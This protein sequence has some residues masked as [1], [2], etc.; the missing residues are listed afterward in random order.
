MNRS[1]IQLFSTATIL[2]AGGVVSCSADNGGGGGGSGYGGA[3]FGGGGGGAGGT[4]PGGNGGM[5][6]GGMGGGGMGGGGMG[7]GGM[8]GGGMGGSG[9][10]CKTPTKLHPPKSDAGTSNIYCP[11]SG[12]D[13][14]MNDYCASG[15][16]HCCEP[17][18]Y[19]SV[20]KCQPLSQPCATG[21]TDWQCQDPVA[22]C[23][24]GQK[25]CGSGTVVKNTDP[26]CANY[27][28]GFTGT[29]CASSCGSD[30]VEICTAN[31]QCAPPKTCLPFGAKGAQVG[32]CY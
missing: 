20:S 6:G 2:A 13:G 17:K 26:L 8:G 31:A 23:P 15:S 25:C 14:G 3:S 30:E 4:A 1:V 11:F 7:G 10:T 12:A 28:T 24:T 22:D 19:G 32:A 9:E 16:E 5:G 29:K 18:A 21:D 27:A